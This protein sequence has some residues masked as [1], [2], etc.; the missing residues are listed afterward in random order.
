MNAFEE[1]SG[2]VDDPCLRKTQTLN[3]L[4]WTHSASCRTCLLKETEI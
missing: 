1:L 3:S 4:K 2:T